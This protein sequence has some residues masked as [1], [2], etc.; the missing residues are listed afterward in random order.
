MVFAA[1]DQ[2]VQPK[3]V[4][5]S[6]PA[7]G[8]YI[9][10]PD[11]NHSDS[12]GKSFL[13][14]S[15]DSNNYSTAQTNSDLD[16]SDLEYNT[17]RPWIHAVRGRSTCTANI[18]HIQEELITE[19]LEQLDYDDIAKAL[20]TRNLLRQ[21]KVIHISSN[22]KFVSIQFNTS[23]MMETFCTEPLKIQDYSVRRQMRQMRTQ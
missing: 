2:R 15:S 14:M 20:H 1:S 6:R 11:T 8:F 13:D 17:Y 22:K 18:Y 10:P 4:A 5:C 9:V 7:G 21:T 3:L 23:T 19:K 16:D 12:V